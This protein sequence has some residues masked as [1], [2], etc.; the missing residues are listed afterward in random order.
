MGA[1]RKGN[2]QDVA[3]EAQADYEIKITN[4]KV[5]TRVTCSE[6]MRY[7]SEVG[8]TRRPILATENS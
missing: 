8:D 2:R 5:L 4:Q 6:S 3:A 7:G 1:V